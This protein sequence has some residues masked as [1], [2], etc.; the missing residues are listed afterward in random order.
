MWWKKDSLA[1]FAHASGVSNTRTFAATFFWTEARVLRDACA[2][3]RLQGCGDGE[4]VVSHRHCDGCTGNSKKNVSNLKV[5][6]RGSKE[7][8]ENVLVLCGCD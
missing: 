3:H 5:K 8:I 1:Q 6:K 4:A 2:R 7:C